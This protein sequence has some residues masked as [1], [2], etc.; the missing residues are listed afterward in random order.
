MGNLKCEVGEVIRVAGP[1]EV[2]QA[3]FRLMLPIR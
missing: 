2:S 1:D 3:V